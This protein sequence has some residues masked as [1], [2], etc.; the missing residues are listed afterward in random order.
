M[1]FGLIDYHARILGVG[2]GF[3][4][5]SCHWT[6]LC[7]WQYCLLGNELEIL[8]YYGNETIVVVGASVKLVVLKLSWRTTNV[9]YLVLV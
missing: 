3:A 5:I 7:N 2:C 8:Y 9:L 6:W 4:S 1:I